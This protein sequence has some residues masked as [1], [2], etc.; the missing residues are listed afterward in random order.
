MIFHNLKLKNIGPFRDTS[1]TFEK[2]QGGVYPVVI[3]TGENGTGKSIILDAIRTALRGLYGIERDVIAD[4]AD[5]LIDLEFVDGQ[6]KKHIT[7]DHI[8]V[9]GKP[10]GNNVY[11]EFFHK[12]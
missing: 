5:F 11:V 6:S 7:A 3:I 1:L 8:A 10:T 4:K 2:E 9:N 12:E